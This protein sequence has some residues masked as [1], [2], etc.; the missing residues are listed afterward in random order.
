MDRIRRE[1]GAGGKYMAEFLRKQVFSKLGSKAR[2]LGEIT[3]EDMEDATDIS[4][5]HVFTT[6]SYVVKPE[7]FPGG[8]IGGL[9]VCGTSNDLAVM[10]AKPKFLSLSLIVQEGFE[11]SKFER[12]MDDASKW[13]KRIGVR[14]ITG[15]TKV[16]S[17]DLGVIINTA[18]IGIRSDELNRNLEVIREYRSYRHSWIRDCGAGD[19][20]AI[21]ISGNIAEHA[22]AVLFARD[23]MGFEMDVKSDVYPVWLFLNKSL[24]VGGITAI[25]DATRGGVAAALNEIAEKSGTGMVVEEEMIPL[26]NEVKSF[27]DV[28][29]LDPLSMANEG[30]VVMCVLKETADDVVKSLRRAGQKNARIVGYTTKKHDEVV[31]RT[32]LGS[33]RILPMP[34]GDPVP[35]IC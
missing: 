27:C 22:V 24:R 7:F 33:K 20:E 25:K 21:I 1:D 31:L 10:G 3:L 32:E 30:V 13:L 17:D 28:L 19:E 4:E 5:D 35:R 29:G 11:T 26:R 23:S 2:E 14:V 16:V 8:N 6:D 9:A 15:D 12:I 34:A 18:G